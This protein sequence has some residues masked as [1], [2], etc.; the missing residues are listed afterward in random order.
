[1]PVV[2]VGGMLMEKGKILL[3]KR[4]NEP[5]RGL[6]AIPG[7]KVNP[8]EKL[9]DALEREFLEE[10]GLIV[11]CGELFYIFEPMGKNNNG[12]LLYHYVILDYLVYKHGGKL[13][14]GSDAAD[15]AWFELKEIEKT[16]DIAEATRKMLVENMAV[17]LKK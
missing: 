9:K 16:P 13:M 17:L 4:A 6:W 11:S 15:A 12:E 3:V 10:T 8:G 1:M 2:A 5:A 7:G 14:K